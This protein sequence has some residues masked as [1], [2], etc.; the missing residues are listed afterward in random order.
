MDMKLTHIDRLL[1]AVS[2]L[3]VGT[4]GVITIVTTPLASATKNVANGSYQR[5]YE[6]RFVDGLPSRQ[7]ATEVWNA[8]RLA[9]L[10]EVNDGAVLGRDG[11]LFTAE[12]FT[13]PADTRD[14]QTELDRARTMLAVSGIQL[15]PVIIPDK[16]RIMRGQLRRGRSVR[17]ATRYDRALEAVERAG[18][19]VVDLRPA[20]LA[21]DAS[22]MRTDT[23]WSPS[24]ARAV[25]YVV[26]AALPDALPP[27]TDF[28]T[29]LTGTKPFEGDLLAF[30]NIGA[31][32]AWVGPA[33]EAIATFA[34]KAVNAVGGDLFGDVTIPV[35][36]IGTSY[37]A[38]ADF[39]FEGF[40][41]HALG[42]DVLNLAEEGNGPFAP[43]ES[44]LNSDT[45][46]SAA[47]QFVIWEIPERYLTTRT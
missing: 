23:H 6:T 5:A 40:L 38:R 8:A 39:H 28:T 37:S 43:M 41:K 33:P 14:L 20:L 7:W 36:L 12:E 15:L 24:G 47:P 42:V 10:G 29:D 31:W 25:A 30:I 35:V 9:M 4:L 27:R 32:R 26:A 45:I 17:F 11:W 44:L 19:P 3:V 1:V 13:E 21:D 22:F 16:A 34:T 18:L 46:E 2:M